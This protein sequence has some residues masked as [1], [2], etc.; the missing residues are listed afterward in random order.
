M[1]KNPRLVVLLTMITAVVAGV[2]PAGAFAATDPGLGTAGNYAVI[3]STTVTNTGPSWITGQVALSPGTSVTGFPPGTS[4]HQDVTNAA[5][6]QARADLTAAYLVA[7]GETPCTTL[8][9][10]LGSPART[11]VAGTY[12]YPAAALLTGTL[13][14]DGAGSGA[15]VWLFQ[16]GAGLTTGSASRVLLINGALPCNVF[17]QVGNS[18][19][20]G[21]STTFVGNIMA[22]TSVAL[23]TTA[24]LNGRAMAR[25]GAVTL[26]TNR[27]IQPTGCGFAAP[28][29][30]AP[31]V[32]PTPTPTASAAATAAPALPNAG[33][34]SQQPGFPWLP[35]GI[36]MT[37]GVVL[38]GLRR[39]AHHRNS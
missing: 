25:N 31:P 38:F 26:D 35:L 28:T 10:D 16:I 23:Q 12:C 11:L 34:P 33:G 29:A 4:G 2:W 30:V 13:T 9:G 7:A 36:A 15:G 32:V 19:V 17:W 27:I 3:G 20:I 5:A 18:A 21:T 24:S 6:A 22:L 8:T 1:F 37:I 14:L 39:R